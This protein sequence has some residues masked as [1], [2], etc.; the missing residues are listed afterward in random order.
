[1]FVMEESS[2]KRGGQCCSILPFSLSVNTSLLSYAFACTNGQI[3]SPTF[4]VTLLAVL[5][6]DKNT[7]FCFFYSC[8]SLTC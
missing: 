3:I 8:P 5:T 1:M 4:C 7:I 2:K 6:L